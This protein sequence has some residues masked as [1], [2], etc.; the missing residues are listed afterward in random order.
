MKFGFEATE[1]NKEIA[2]LSPGGRARLLFA[3]FS[4]LSANIL[5]LDEP[6]NHLDLEALEALEEA[7]THYEGTIVLVSHDRYFLEKFRPT[8]TYVLSEGKL[9]RQESF[10]TYATSAE[11]QAKRLIRMI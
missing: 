4:A 10:K 6:T 1:I 7:V 8:D 2:A 11:R 3:L 5:I 9:T